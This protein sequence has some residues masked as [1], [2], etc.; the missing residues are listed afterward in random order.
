MAVILVSYTLKQQDR[1]Y[2][3][4][5]DYLQKFT[6]CRGMDSIWLLD[7]NKSPSQI[8]DD[9]GTLIDHND[10][11]FVTRMAGDWAARHSGYGDWLNHTSRSWQ[12]PSMMADH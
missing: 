12:F 8:R 10:A 1:N 9:I 2:Q 7:T 3:N 11:V 4:V 6:H 5:Y